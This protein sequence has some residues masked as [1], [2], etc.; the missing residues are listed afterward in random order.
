M[1]D[2][3]QW[4]TEDQLVSCSKGARQTYMVGTS[5]YLY[6]TKRWTELLS[7]VQL[8]TLARIGDAGEDE[9]VDEEA[10]TVRDRRLIALRTRR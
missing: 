1:A 9:E 4:W 10:L 7:P 3:E 8:Q 2:Q 5:C 6:N